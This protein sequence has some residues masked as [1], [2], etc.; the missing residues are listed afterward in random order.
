MAGAGHTQ[1]S[2]TQKT[3]HHSSR[4]VRLESTAKGRPSPQPSR[5]LPRESLRRADAERRDYREGLRSGAEGRCDAGVCVMIRR[6]MMQEQELCDS[7]RER[8]QKSEAAGRKHSIF[9]T[10]FRATAK[11]PSLE[12]VVIS[13]RSAASRRRRRFL[14]AIANMIDRAV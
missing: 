5:A 11:R 13:F 8:A 12:V 14:K 6:K 1:L 10:A 9:G 4:T 7:F 3:Q 2:E